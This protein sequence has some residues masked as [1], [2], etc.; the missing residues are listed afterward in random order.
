MSERYRPFTFKP[1]QGGRLM[2]A[3]TP[4]KAGFFN[5]TTKRDWRRVLDKEVRAEGYDWFRPNV[6]IPLG[7]QPYPNYPATDEPITLLVMARRPNGK[8]AVV[9]GTQTKLWRYFAL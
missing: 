3:T 4:E 5:Y 1:G 9:A 6:G 8:L 7:N 2:T